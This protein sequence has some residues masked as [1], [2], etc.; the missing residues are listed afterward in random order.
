M[1]KHTVK[2]NR[3]A[4]KKKTEKILKYMKDKDEETRIDAIRALG[5]CGGEEAFNH[6]VMQLSSQISRERMEAAKALGK[7]G[8][9]AAFYQLSHYADMETDASV[10]E[11][12]KDAMGQIHKRTKGR[13][14]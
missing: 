7:C 14:E 1:G 3:L 12:M 8:P 6:L 10:K 4:E 11:A 5:E 13:D 2:I 9:D